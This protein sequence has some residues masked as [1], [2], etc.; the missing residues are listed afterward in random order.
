MHGWSRLFTAP[1]PHR[2]P[3]PRP[4]HGTMCLLAIAASLLAVSCTE[5]TRCLPGRQP[6]V[7][8]IVQDGATQRDLTTE[9]TVIAWRQG[10]TTRDTALAG[11]SPVFDG[12][13]GV[14]QVR[15]EHPDHMPWESAPFA[16][17]AG[18]CS[19]VATVVVRVLMGIV[20]A[21]GG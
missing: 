16:V 20:G 14:W 21:P 15:V 6:A 7:V 1:H 4:P 9:S 18:E 11:Q 10:Q 2:P 3:R 12:P 8:V 19:E 5:P 17:R 13:A